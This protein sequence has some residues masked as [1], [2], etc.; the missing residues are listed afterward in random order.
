MHA[1]CITGRLLQTCRCVGSPV[2]R[3]HRGRY[4]C[5]RWPRRRGRS[6]T[7]RGRAAVGGPGPR[8]TPGHRRAGGAGGRD[9]RGP[10]PGP[11]GR[12]PHHARLFRR[13]GHRRR[14]PGRSVPDH[15]GEGVCHGG[16]AD[17]EVDECVTGRPGAA[18]AP[19]ASRHGVRTSMAGSW[20]PAPLSA[21]ASVSRRALNLVGWCVKGVACGCGRA[22]GWGPAGAGMA[23]W[24]GAFGCVLLLEADRARGLS[25]DGCWRGEWWWAGL[26]PALWTR[27]GPSCVIGLPPRWADSGW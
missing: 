20:I 23:G 8:P 17:A 13:E 3:Q 21:V 19:P 9:P 25:A 4:G 12:S 16:G 15:R 2:C 27:S 11:P 18:V 5:G 26:R 22:P 6:A 24:G 1:P 7:R 14:S 10:S